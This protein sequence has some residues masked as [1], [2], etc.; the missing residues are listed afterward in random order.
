MYVRCKDPVFVVAF[1][2]PSLVL[3]ASVVTIFILSSV[4]FRNCLSLQ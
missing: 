4:G 3:V 2:L 1:A